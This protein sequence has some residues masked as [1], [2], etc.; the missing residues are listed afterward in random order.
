VKNK[1]STV[2]QGLCLA[3]VECG[4]CYE[5]VGFIVRVGIGALT[6]VNQQV[7]PK[8]AGT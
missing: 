8:V 7:F 1:V 4:S 3:V 5:H 6:N 2:Q